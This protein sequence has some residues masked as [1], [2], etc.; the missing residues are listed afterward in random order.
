MSSSFSST[1][2]STA[3]AQRIWDRDETVYEDLDHIVEWIGDGKPAS[4][5]IL[6]SY[7]SRFDFKDLYLEQAFR[8]L[9]SKL[10]LKGETQQIDRILLQFSER[11][12]ECNP[13]CIFGTPGKV[14]VLTFFLFLRK[15]KK[16]MISIFKTTI[17]VC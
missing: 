2:D 4:N 14:Q 3:I 10:S 15:K 1:S 13:R 7:I 6:R 5:A 16:K 17:D 8:N 12:F 9:C 11:Y